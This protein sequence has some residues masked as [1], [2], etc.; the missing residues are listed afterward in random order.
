MTYNR[1]EIMKAAWVIYR[2]FVGNDETHHQRLART[3]S[4]AWSEA[5]MNANIERSRSKTKKEHEALAARPIASLRNEIIKLENKT[6]LRPEGMT[7]LANLKAAYTTAI[8]A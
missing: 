6:Y 2:R 8:H 5:K 7:Y 3:I 1:S 4:F